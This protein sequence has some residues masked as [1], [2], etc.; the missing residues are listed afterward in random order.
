MFIPNDS[1]KKILLKAGV[2][3]EATWNDVVTNAQRLGVPVEDIL[4]ERDIIAGHVFY[5]I[6]SRALNFSY[7]NL[8]A[9]D[10]DER[11]LNLFDDTV[12]GKYK[13]IPFAYDPKTRHVK[14]AFLDPSNKKN[15]A[16][17]QRKCRAKIDVYFT[18]TSSFKFASKYY[19]HSVSEAI[20]KMIEKS[21]RHITNRHEKKRKTSW[22]KDV[23]KLFHSLIEFVYYTQPSDIHIEAQKDGGVIKMRID[24]FLKD[25]FFLPEPI[26]KEIVSI[27]KH[28]SGIHTDVHH[29]TKDSR[30]S[31]TI[32]SET[33]SFRVSII[34]TYYGEKLCL[35][36]LDESRQKTSLRDLGFS[37]EYVEMIKQEMKKPYGLILVTGPTGS[38]KSSTLYSLLKF[39]NIEGVS[40]A[41]IE[42]PVEYAVPHVNQTQVDVDNGFT[43]AAGLRTILRQDPNIVMVG[44]IRDSET[45]AITIQSALTGHIVIS[46][47]HSNTAVGAITRLKNMDMK[48]Y[49]LAPTLNLIVSQR[50]VK[51]IC[52]Y[53]PEKY[54]A[55]KEL[56]DRIDKDA[57]LY[58]SL[59]KLQKRGVLATTKPEEL[60]FY[61]SKGCVKCKGRGTAGRIG[62]FEILNIDSEMSHLI[63]SDKNEHIIQAKAESNG[64]LTLFEDGLLKAL[65]GYITLEELMRIIE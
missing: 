36:V 60:S 34:P 30:F 3:D 22:E 25:E 7:I 13:A 37:D 44:E 64:M 21:A 11:V 62:V 38:G 33:I 40:I 28:E 39:L 47:L 51:M 46:T 63:A 43:F 59:E 15:I 14:V 32:F 20:K 1:L 54:S 6:V 27:I 23:Q 2:I 61:R 24:G 10:I 18:G 55:S 9:I 53:C 4:K 17:L 56:L 29:Q 8:K 19:Q 16:A 57:K 45:A 48:P 41:T 31:R 58:Q 42:D 52:P 65:N 5:E 26:H 49:L 12:V 35:R 50:L